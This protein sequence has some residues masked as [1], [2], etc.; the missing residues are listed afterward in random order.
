MSRFSIALL[1]YSVGI[2]TLGGCG[3]VQSPEP[4]KVLSHA[5]L[6]ELG[7]ENKLMDGGLNRRILNEALA[8]RGDKIEL[9]EDGSVSIQPGTYRISGISLITMQDG[10]TPIQA[11]EVYPGYCIVYD[12]RYSGREALSN[13]V[14]VGTMGVALY[15]SPSLFDTVVTFSA[16]TDICLGH[17]A[18]EEIE[19]D[20]YLTYIDG[21]P[22]G[23]SDARIFAQ[24]SIFELAP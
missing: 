20:V 16:P 4:A 23:P 7:Q 17:Q 11:N 10:L 3:E 6:A 13:A 18:G 1:V 9:H 22:A 8:E 12:C 2:I 24:M 5:V 15:S 14:A 19:E 21:D